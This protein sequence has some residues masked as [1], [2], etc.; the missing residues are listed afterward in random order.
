M[1]KQICIIVLLLCMLI[2]FL[3]LKIS[4]TPVSENPEVTVQTNASSDVQVWTIEEFEAWMDEKLA[5]YQS[6]VDQQSKSYYEKNIDG[7]YVTRVWTQNDVEEYRKSWKEQLQRMKEG[8]V[9]T[10]PIDG[11]NLVGVFEPG[12]LNGEDGLQ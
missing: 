11:T 3:M 2:A 9:Y 5:E 6:L 7:V 8:Y 1:K 4:S 10:K 12:I